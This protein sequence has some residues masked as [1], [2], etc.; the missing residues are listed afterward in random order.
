MRVLSLLRTWTPYDHGNLCVTRAHNLPQQFH[1]LVISRLAAWV[2][3]YTVHFSV[4]SCWHFP[5]WVAGI[6]TVQVITASLDCVTAARV[7]IHLSVTLRS[8]VKTS[9]VVAHCKTAIFDCTRRINEALI[10]GRLLSVHII[11]PYPTNIHFQKGREVS[12][13]RDRHADL[14]RVAR[15][16]SRTRRPIAIKV[17]TTIKPLQNSVIL[18]FLQ[19]VITKWCPRKLLHLAR[20]YSHLF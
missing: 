2:L 12:C 13:L 17:T 9:S 11:N 18:N 1:I 5:A 14:V 10:Y 20:Q 16:T 3:L 7:P 6:A 15:W 8:F 19:S 4:N